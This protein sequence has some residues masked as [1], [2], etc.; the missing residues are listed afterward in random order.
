MGIKPS[1][2]NASGE[3]IIP[4]SSEVWN[5][6][7][8]FMKIKVLR[9][10]IQLDLDE[11]IAIFGRKDMEENILPEM[12][13][14]KRAEALKR[15]I[16]TLRQLM[17]NCKFT[18]DKNQFDRKTIK[19]LFNRI[20]QVENVIDGI[21][22][23]VSNDI[24]KENFLMINEEHFQICFRVLRDIKD[25]LNILIDRAGLIF[26]RSDEVNLDD[27]MRNVMEGN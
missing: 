24:T 8:G 14:I 26:R 20:Y 6:S 17:G 7:D 21:S 27:L 23:D 9:L 16:F 1:I 4:P 22:Y 3:K 18:I 25:E 11:S 19:I 2:G 12:V 15:I 10:L 13:N 5:I